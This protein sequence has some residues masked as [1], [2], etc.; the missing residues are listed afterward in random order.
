MVDHF[1][2]TKPLP[3]VELDAIEEWVEKL[4]E[5]RLSNATINHR[6]AALSK[7]FTF[8]HRRVKASGVVVKPYIPRRKTPQARLRYLTREEE[9]RLVATLRQWEHHDAADAVEVLVDT[10]LR[11]GE[12][13]RLRAKDIAVD[14]RSV[15]IWETKNE[16]PRTV[17]LTNR[18]S[19]ILGRRAEKHKERLFPYSGNWI[20]PVWDRARGHLGYADDPHFVPHILRHTCASRL[21]QGGA[22]VKLIGDWLGHKSL[23]VTQKYMVLAPSSLS[24]AVGLLEAAE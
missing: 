4:E 20:R 13:N 24:G 17:P 3:E 22:N 14:G 16:D 21:A 19:V 8:A 12:L 6:L 9:G 7:F 5:A 2:R 1:G 10:G 11:M 18:S 15:T 23:Q